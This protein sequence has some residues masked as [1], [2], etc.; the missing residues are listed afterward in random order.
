MGP[1]RR[2]KE[3]TMRDRTI[4][5]EAVTCRTVS[6]KEYIRLHDA[7]PAAIKSS[8]IVPAKLGSRSFGKIEV[9]FKTPVYEAK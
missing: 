5:L 3:E 1:H 7:H 6:P 9:F 2:I 4:I 8:R